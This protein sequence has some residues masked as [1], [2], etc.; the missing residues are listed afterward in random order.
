MNIYND[1]GFAQLLG[2]VLVF[3]EEFLQLFFLRTPLG[4]GAAL[5][6]GQALENTGQALPAPGDE[7]RGVKPFTA[8][9][10][11]DGARLSGSGIGLSQNPQFVLRREGAA[12][13]VNDY[14]RVWSRRTGRLGRHGVVE[15]IPLF[16][17]L[18]PV[19]ALLSNYD[20]GTVSSMLARR[21]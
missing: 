18:I 6:R 2:Q 13:G 5:V 11:S 1:L 15:D 9:Q 4:L 17:T 14:L 7:V 21:G 10:G 12:L 19:L 16:F 8:L 20:R 3:P